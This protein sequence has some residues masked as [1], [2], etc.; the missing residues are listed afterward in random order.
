MD[1]EVNKQELSHPC[2]DAQQ[3]PRKPAVFCHLCHHILTQAVQ[4]S[5]RLR[6][7]CPSCQR[8]HN[9]ESTTEN[10]WQECAHP[11]WLH[12]QEVHGN[13]LFL[14]NRNW[15]SRCRGM[16][17]TK[18]LLIPASSNSCNYCVSSK[19]MFIKASHGSQMWSQTPR[20]TLRQLLRRLS[21]LGFMV[22]RPR[23]CHE[24]SMVCEMKV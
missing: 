5:V 20:T 9:R 21:E 10:Q 6:S 19:G 23:R 16:K 22:P 24:I 4:Y 17:C 11:D 7:T 18:K 14:A 15:P 2:K 3:I 1:A 8:K 13:P 12:Q